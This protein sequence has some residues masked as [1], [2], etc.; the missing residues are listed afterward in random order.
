VIAVA[1]TIAWAE[2]SSGHLAEWAIG[3]FAGFFGGAV[4][5]AAAVGIWLMALTR[6]VKV[7]QDKDPDA[8]VVGIVGSSETMLALALGDGEAALGQGQY[9]MQVTRDGVHLWRK[10]VAPTQFAFIPRNTVGAVSIAP[11]RLG[12]RSV[13]RLSIV[14]HTAGG[15]FDVPIYPS[16][17]GLKALFNQSRPGLEKLESGIRAILRIETLPRQP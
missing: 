11:G 2:I 13:S 5:L 3:Y 4:V 16:Y 1:I 7:I 9:V 8:I 15:D 12:I 17:N 14:V 6:R 10:Y